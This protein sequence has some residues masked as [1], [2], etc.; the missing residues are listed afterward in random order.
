MA[1]FKKTPQKKKDAAMEY[2]EI[3]QDIPKPP[4]AMAE[5]PVCDCQECQK[6][7]KV[8]ENQQTIVAN[9]QVILNSIEAVG[10]LIVKLAGE[11]PAEEPEPTQE[12][13]EAAIKAARAAKKTGGK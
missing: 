4:A 8:L 2:S 3:D 10:Q 6:I 13:I 9:Q 5:P 7:R 12:E 11:A 1:L